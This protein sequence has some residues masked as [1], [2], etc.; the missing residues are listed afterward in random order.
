MGIFSRE[1]IHMTDQDH[2]TYPFKARIITY[3]NRPGSR[4]VVCYCIFP[5]RLCLVS[6]TSIFRNACVLPRCFDNIKVAEQTLFFVCPATFI[7]LKVAEQTGKH[8]IN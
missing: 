3:S 5:T 6:L 1:G 2:S 4:Q 7:F 8:I